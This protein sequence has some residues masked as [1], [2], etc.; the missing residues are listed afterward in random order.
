MDAQTDVQIELTEGVSASIDLD[1]LRAVVVSLLAEERRTGADSA[2]GTE[3]AIQL[4]DDE[5]LRALNAQHRGID[6]PTDVLS[7]GPLEPSED[8]AFPSPES[9]GA[10]YLGDIVVSVEYAQ[11]EA[12]AGGLNLDE[13]L[14]HLVVHG[15]LHLLGFD[16]E[17]EDDAAAMER[18]EEALLGP[19]IHRGQTH[20]DG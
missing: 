9:G 13:E 18:R 8:E 2:D 5:L 4:A 19:D 10:D 11:R 6:A 15:V 14:Q 12:V 1:G 20:E 17:T 7:F 16:H 3:L